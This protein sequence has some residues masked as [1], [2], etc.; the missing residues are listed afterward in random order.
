MTAAIDVPER[1]NAATHFV[2]RHLAEGR[3][4]RTAFRFHGRS[5]TYAEV[6]LRANRLKGAVLDVF[7]TEPLPP[8][9]PL[10]GLPNVLISPHTAA[11]SVRENERLTS[12]FI[13]NLGRYLAGEELLSLVDTDLFY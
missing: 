12:L 13:A 5:V 4:D 1:F 9:S 3:G 10:W 2:D 7:A 8:E 6:A 11:L